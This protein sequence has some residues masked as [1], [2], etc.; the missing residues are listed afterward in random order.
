MTSSPEAANPDRIED[1]HPQHD[2]L[3]ERSD[4]RPTYQAQH[5]MSSTLC[6]GETICN[7]VWSCKAVQRR[8]YRVHIHIGMQQPE[9]S[10]PQEKHDPT[11]DGSQQEKTCRICYDGENETQGRLIK[12]CLCTGSISVSMAHLLV[13]VR[14]C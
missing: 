8:L 6:G 5:R 3:E 10:Q 14:E 12:P 11:S 4:G 1:S 2:L 9:D 13:P 7:R